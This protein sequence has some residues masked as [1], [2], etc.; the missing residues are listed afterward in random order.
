MIT[1]IYEKEI[2]LKDFEYDSFVY[3]YQQV[4][5]LNNNALK[6]DEK[7]FKNNAQPENAKNTKRL[8]L[9]TI[10]NY[11][12]HDILMPFPNDKYESAVEYYLDL[13]RAFLKE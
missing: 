3:E 11:D 9:A 12:S 1:K 4:I 2:D 13:K 7:E 6:V 10:G 5:V 8:L